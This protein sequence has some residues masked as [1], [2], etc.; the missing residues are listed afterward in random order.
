[1][2]L[3]SIAEL[4]EQRVPSSSLGWPS[5]DRGRLSHREQ[6]R[7]L[8]AAKVQSFWELAGAFGVKYAKSGRK[9]CIFITFARLNRV[10]DCPVE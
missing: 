5:R 2:M 10:T 8:L 3:A 6:F 7:G 1:M 4:M 9:C